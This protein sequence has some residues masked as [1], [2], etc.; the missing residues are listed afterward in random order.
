MKCLIAVKVHD[1]NISI[2]KT[3][4]Y[5]TMPAPLEQYFLDRGDYILSSRNEYVGAFSLALAKL[6]NNNVFNTNHP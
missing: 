4:Y 3:D 2:E 6:D 5:S 1:N